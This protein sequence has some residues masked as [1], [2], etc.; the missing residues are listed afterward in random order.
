MAV[1]EIRTAGA[2]DLN[3]I[4]RAPICIGDSGGL[5]ETHGVR[6]FLGASSSSWKPKY[7][8]QAL[9]KF[10]SQVATPGQPQEWN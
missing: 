7:S 8:A 2:V 5:L 10:I 9:M 1:R 6:V 3:F 4:P